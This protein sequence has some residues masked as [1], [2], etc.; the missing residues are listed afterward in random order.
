VAVGGYRIGVAD[1]DRARRVARWY[2]D[3]FAAAAD[4]EE[5]VG[6]AFEGLVDAARRYDPGRG[7]F[8]RYASARVVGSI[9]DELR[10]EDHL[11]RDARA[12]VVD[13][14]DGELEFEGC[15][16]F[17]APHRPLSLDAGSANGGVDGELGDLVGARDPELEQ[18]ELADA[19]ARGLQRLPDRERLVVTLLYFEQV[20]LKRIGEL[21]G[22]G[23]SRVCHLH[24]RALRRL[25]GLVGGGLG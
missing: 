22:I 20:T 21:L 10:R 14:P 24:T 5:L 9:R 6:A 12:D 3:R 25:R 11:S 18:V 2:R 13:T 7:E 16:I 15:G 17:A 19:V 8:W 1:V 4:L 23:E